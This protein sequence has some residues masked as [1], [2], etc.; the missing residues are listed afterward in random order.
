MSMNKRNLRDIIGTRLMLG[1]TV[2]IVALFFIIFFMLLFKSFPLFETTSLSEVL[3][4]TVWN[5]E[6][7]LFGLAGIIIGTILVTGISLLIAIPV[8]I[9]C[10]IYISEYAHEKVRHMIR[11]FIDV[12]AGVPSVVYGLCAFLILVPFTR[13]VLAPFFGVQ[14]TGLC[15]FTASVILSVMVF[16]IITSLCIEA[17]SA[18]PIELKEASLSLGA[19]KW[20]TMKKVLF[21]KARYN[22]VSAIFLGFGR[23]FGETIAVNM[24]IGGLPRIPQTLFHPGQTL[25]SL[26]VSAYSEMMSVPLYESALMFVALVLFIVVLI[27]NLLGVLLLRRSKKRYA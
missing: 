1:I 16:P 12:L 14:S 26:I 7:G 27:F 24:V 9:L 22:V 11:P 18:I 13:D 10:A 8:S 3:F 19:T 5:P 2:V 23:A 15:V 17:F 20:E 21:K 6:R 4:S 25:A